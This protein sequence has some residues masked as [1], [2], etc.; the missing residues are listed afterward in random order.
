MRYFF[1]T[2]LRWLLCLLEFAVAVLYW[3]PVRLLWGKNTFDYVV[4]YL[5]LKGWLKKHLGN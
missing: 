5:S 4:E 3:L 2:L 1:Y